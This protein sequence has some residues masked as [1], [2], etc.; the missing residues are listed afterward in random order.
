MFKA[1]VLIGLTG[2]FSQ[3][4]TVFKIQLF[5]MRKICDIIL[6]YIQFIF[7]C[8]KPTIVTDFKM[9]KERVCLY[10][11]IFM[12]YGSEACFGVVGY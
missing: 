9:K 3:F 4:K 11:S 12:D 1:D 8:L 5:Y 10:H 2:L 7:N 6:Y